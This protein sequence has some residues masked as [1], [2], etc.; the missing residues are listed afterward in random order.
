MTPEKRR[1]FDRLL[2]PRHIA[3]IGGTDAMIGCGSAK[4][5][6]VGLRVRIGPS[7][8]SGIICAICRALPA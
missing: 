1:H 6:D 5:A 2:S 4:P 7:I 8:P 3:F